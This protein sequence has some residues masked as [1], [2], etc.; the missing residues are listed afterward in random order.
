[1]GTLILG[2]AKSSLDLRG[3]KAQKME[4]DL[5]R[6][7]YAVARLRHGG[8][9]ARAYLLV[10][11]A[12]LA[13]RVAVWLEKYE[14][15]DAVRILVA[16]PD[17]DELARLRAEKASNVE[18]MAAGVTGEEAGERSSAALGEAYGERMLGEMIAELEDGVTRYEGPSPLG[19]RWDFIGMVP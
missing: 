8:Q 15:P 1:M 2:M 18:G 3:A 19:V 9:A 7:V 14:S 4:L 16:A 6:L 17:S 5:L 13:R 12:A 10:M 11:N